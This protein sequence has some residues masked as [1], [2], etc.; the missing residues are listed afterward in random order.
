MTEQL[1]KYELEPKVVK[2]LLAA[3]NS[4]Q[5]R[6]E[7]QVKDVITV[8]EVLR[9]PNNTED[10]EKSQLESLKEKYESVAKKEKK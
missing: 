10:L 2:Y 7:Q 9:N 8:L 1:Y 4:Q 6:G 3:V 5:V